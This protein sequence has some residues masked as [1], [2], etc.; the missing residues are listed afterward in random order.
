[1]AS[2]TKFHCTVEPIEFDDEVQRRERRIL[3][4][5]LRFDDHMG[6]LHVYSNVL[7]P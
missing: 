4:D 3:H 2:K 6:A 1:M 5:V 7:G